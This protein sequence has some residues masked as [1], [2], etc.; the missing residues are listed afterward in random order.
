MIYCPFASRGPF[1]V[2][3]IPKKHSASFTGI[4]VGE[5]KE[6]AATLKHILGRIRH[7]LNDPSYNFYIHTMP[8]CLPQPAY[9]DPASY[10][11]HLEILPR[12]NTWAG[13]EL[14]TEIYINPVAPEE[15]A[16]VLR[17]DK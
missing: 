10:H 15:G 12:I 5:Q 8:V 3:I 4:S 14:G 11:W 16:G 17:G 7:E 6:L 2:R 1:Q 13:F 9:C